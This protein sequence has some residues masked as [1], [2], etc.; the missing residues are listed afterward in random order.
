MNR[1]WNLWCELS[2]TDSGDSRLKL[3]FNTDRRAATLSAHAAALVEGFA[4]YVWSTNPGISQHEFL[5]CGWLRL[6][7]TNGGAPSGEPQLEL[8]SE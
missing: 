3:A 4:T 8:F 7:R 2:C 5:T 6:P 1:L